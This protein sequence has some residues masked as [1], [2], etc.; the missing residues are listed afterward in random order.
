MAIFNFA[1]HLRQKEISFVLKNVQVECW[2]WIKRIE[3]FLGSCREMTRISSRQVFKEFKTKVWS[4]WWGLWHTLLCGRDWCYWARCGWG[5]LLLL[6]R[7][8]WSWV[9]C[10]C[11]NRTP[12]IAN[13]GLLLLWCRLLGMVRVVMGWASPS[14]THWHWLWHLKA[15]WHL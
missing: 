4:G 8:W 1:A 10:S 6:L 15:H 5:V 13:N 14:C 11:P 9:P 12:S 7:W 3:Q 2:G